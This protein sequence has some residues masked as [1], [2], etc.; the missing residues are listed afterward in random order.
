LAWAFI[1]GSTDCSWADEGGVGFWLLGAYGS[2][3]AVPQQPGW[4]LS[5]V[6]YHTDVSA[7]GD[8][9]RARKSEESLAI[10]RQA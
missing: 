10:C 5:T 8:V 2:L 3:A 1:A 9:A 7:S 4:S 6:Y